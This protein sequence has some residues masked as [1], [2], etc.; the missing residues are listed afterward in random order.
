MYSKQK[1]SNNR[2][3]VN[4]KLYRKEASMKEALLWFVRYLERWKE[5]D[6]AQS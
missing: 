1:T 6:L 2:Q 3:I 5:K 4:L